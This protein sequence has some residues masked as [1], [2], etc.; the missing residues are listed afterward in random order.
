MLSSFIGI[1]FLDD[2]QWA[3]PTALGLV[4]AVLSGIEDSKSFVSVG[5][6]SS[7]GFDALFIFSLRFVF[8]SSYWW[9]AIVPVM[10]RMDSSYLTFWDY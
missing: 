6:S 10:L 3:D 7:F 2:L 4:H 8:S 5:V 1:L 9:E